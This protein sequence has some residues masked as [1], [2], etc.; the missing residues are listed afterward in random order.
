MQLRRM[1]SC[2]A[3]TGAL[4]APAQARNT[5][6]FFPAH[7]AAESDVGRKSLAGVPF[8]LRGEEH[9]DLGRE[10]QE[11]SAE[12]S[13]RGVFRSDLASCQVAFLSALRVLEEHAKRKGAAAIVDIISVTRG[14]E[15]ESSTD[16]RCIAGTTVVHVGLRGK[17]VAPVD[18]SEAP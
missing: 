4:A 2:V 8:Y 9:P 6:H 17:L 5:E 1:I 3:L 15:T 13:T 7:E 14:V 10:L 11:V 12:R 16:F 18:E